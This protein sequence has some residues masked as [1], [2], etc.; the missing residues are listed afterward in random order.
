ML[1]VLVSVACPFVDASPQDLKIAPLVIP[2]MSSPQEL[3]TAQDQI[4]SEVQNIKPR[5]RSRKATAVSNGIYLESVKIYDEGALE[6][7]LSSARA[8]LAQLNAFDQTSLISHLGAIQGST[9]NQTQSAIQV[10]GPTQVPAGATPSPVTPNNPTLPAPSASYTL[11]STFQTSAVDF[12]NEQMQVS[13][14]MIELQLLLGGSYNDQFEVESNVARIRTTL[15]FP[16]NI[17]VPPGFKYQK[18]V[19]E[20]SISVCAPDS[21]SP[22]D[23]MSNGGLTLAT[24]L[25]QEK[26]YNVASLVSK[27]SSVGGGV[28]AGVVNV[29]GGLLWSRQTYYLVQDTDTLALQRHPQDSCKTAD[30]SATTPVAFAWQFRPVLGQKVVRDG[31]RQTYAQISFPK[32]VDAHSKAPLRLLVRTGW[33]HYDSK[34]GRVGSEIDPFQV[35]LLK[36]ERF[37]I[38][39]SPQHVTASDN[40]D[41]TVTVLAKGSFKAGTRVR[42][43]GI[44]IDNTVAGFE[45]N[46][47]Y[48]R[49]T[50]PVSL[51][52]LNRP[53][54]V[55]LDGTE[56]EIKN[57]VEDLP[58]PKIDLQPNSGE[59]GR[60]VRNA[61]IYGYGTHFTHGT[62]IVSFADPGITVR[63]RAIVDDTHMTVT[64]E[65]AGTAQY[66][67]S[68]VRVLVESDAAPETA[69]GVFTV[70]GDEDTVTIEPFNDSTSI[71][72]L[73]RPASL[74]SSS[75]DTLEAV[76]VGARVYGL[77]D[78]PFYRRSGDEIQFLVTN[79]LIRTN[80]QIIWKR[81]FT[82]G[83]VHTYRILFPPPPPTGVSDFAI[84]SVALVSYTAGSPSSSAAGVFSPSNITVSTNSEVA[85][86]TNLFLIGNG[87]PA[88]VGISKANGEPGEILRDVTLTGAFTHF[89]RRTPVLT[90]SNP[91]IIAS[92][93]TVIDDSHLKADLTITPA[94]LK[95]PSNITIA[96]APEVAIGTGTFNVGS[97]KVL[98]AGATPSTG[99]RS[100]QLQVTITGDATHFVQ[101]QS[102]L[103]FSNAGIVPGNITVTDST[104]LTVPVTIAP[105]A[106]NGPSD[107]SVVT[108]AETAMGTGLFTVAPRL[109]I[110]T[111][112]TPSAGQQSQTIS[113][114][115]VAGA[116]THFTQ[117][118]PSVT[119]ANPGIVASDVTVQDDTHLKVKLNIAPNAGAAGPTTSETTGASQKATNTYAIS[120]SKLSG[121][122][123]LVPSGVSIDEPRADTLITFSLTDEQA[124]SFKSIVVQHN[125]DQPIVVALPSPPPAPSA[126]A[127]K[128]SIKPQPPAG[129]P[130]G[131]NTLTVS[132][133]GMSQV[134]SVRYLDAPIAFTASS[135][136]ALTIQ[137]LPTLTQPGIELIFVYGDKSMTSYFIPV[138][139]PGP[140]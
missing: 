23:L 20:I 24:L 43:G 140:H 62:P 73:K 117:A 32:D 124:K 116:F 108:G 109:P 85:N 37:D 105:N 16:I 78:A 68:D 1:A 77:R 29:G 84:T 39:P 2:K 79:D 115:T 111:S 56:A 57:P 44:V 46:Q 47:R 11:P 63:D 60:T 28:V 65:I 80:R 90:L 88:I 106:P 66:G 48:L 121:V 61:T 138:Q 21:V 130:I 72:K 54:L 64:L 134:V 67:N 49:F 127:P 87:T 55:N 38:P 128:P 81:L 51:L 35:Q 94:A 82:S 135:D 9:A 98:I 118:K 103:K 132:G 30:G 136:T 8:N 76:S 95:G 96:T 107:I 27:S 36:A 75:S 114:V 101:G 53:Y 52:L 102:A 99:E 71:V 137:Q 97:A 131:T 19:A 92:N 120:G 34:T 119:F 3:G 45:Q 10:T 50:A 69:Y 110:I 83:Q 7:L 139:V 133:T 42:L 74:F 13:M 112:I 100:G 59:K 125:T 104:H 18:A 22:A 123:I 129:I 126:P 12:L 91:G 113:D 33:R 89:S 26:T 14:K 70:T 17:S 5:K 40:G 25:P 41:G 122:R 93:L 31:L 58:N 86:G 6:G 15:G 4:R